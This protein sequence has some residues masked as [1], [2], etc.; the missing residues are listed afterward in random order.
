MSALTWI[1]VGL[2]GGCAALARVAVDGFTA[3]AL[4]RVGRAAGPRL[5]VGTFV[6]N[7]TGSFL[8]GLVDG[9]AVSGDASILIATAGIGTYTTFSTWMLQTQMLGSD[10]LGRAAF[11]NVSASLVVGFGAVAAGHALGVAL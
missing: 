4:T 10:H 3:R 11:M 1:G 6:V 5:A 2:I 9:L 8:L 7:L